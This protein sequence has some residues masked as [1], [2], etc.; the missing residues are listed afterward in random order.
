M[1]NETDDKQVQVFMER[2]FRNPSFKKMLKVC[3]VSHW[4][5]FFCADELVHPQDTPFTLFHYKMI[6]PSLHIS[7]WR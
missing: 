4:C 3:L 1:T 6:I 2:Y 5:I 7:G